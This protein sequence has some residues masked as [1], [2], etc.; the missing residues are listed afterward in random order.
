M[1]GINLTNFWTVHSAISRNH[2]SQ[3]AEMDITEYQQEQVQ[4]HVERPPE[5]RVGEDKRMES[6]FEDADEAPTGNVGGVNPIEEN[7]MQQENHENHKNVNAS[8]DSSMLDL[9]QVLDASMLARGGHGETWAREDVDMLMDEVFAA[10]HIV[11]G[12]LSA[13]LTANMKA[14]KWEATGVKISR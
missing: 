14:D 9:S 13:T 4:E 6:M 2:D 8:H 12:N 10:Y 7:I 3:Q 5:R 1:A 11:K